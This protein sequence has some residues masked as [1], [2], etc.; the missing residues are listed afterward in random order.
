MRM[1]CYVPRGPLDVTSRVTIK[2][3]GYD[4]SN[5][6]AATSSKLYFMR[7]E[8]NSALTDH[9]LRVLNNLYKKYLHK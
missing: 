2:L 3:I 7:A 9:E 6:P 4:A 8:V 5:M 1:K